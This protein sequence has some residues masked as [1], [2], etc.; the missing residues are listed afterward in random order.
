MDESERHPAGSAVQPFKPDATAIAPA[1]ASGTD[2]VQRMLDSLMTA[3]TEAARKFEERILNI[4]RKIDALLA[5][6]SVVHNNVVLLYKVST[7]ALSAKDVPIIQ[8]GK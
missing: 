6:L 1:P 5:G 2:A 4:E 3:D 8:V 7:G